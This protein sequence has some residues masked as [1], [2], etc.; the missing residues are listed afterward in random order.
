MPGYDSKRKGSLKNIVGT[1]KVANPES[2]DV[3]KLKNSIHMK[4]GLY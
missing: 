3:K 2:I 1:G 4:E